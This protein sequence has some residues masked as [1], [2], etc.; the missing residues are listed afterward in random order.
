MTARGAK[1]STGAPFDNKIES[2]INAGS[3]KDWELPP[4]RCAKEKGEPLDGKETDFAKISKGELDLTKGS[5]KFE[6]GDGDRDGENTDQAEEQGDKVNERDD[7]EG[8]EDL[9]LTIE[10]GGSELGEG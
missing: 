10:S 5:D 4:L 6:T 2:S 9:E 3:S 7:G 8:E 1:V